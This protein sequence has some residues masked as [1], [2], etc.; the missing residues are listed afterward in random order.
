LFHLDQE[1][2][3]GITANS[4]HPG[5]IGTNIV[6]REVG[7]TMPPGKYPNTLLYS[8]CYYIYIYIYILFV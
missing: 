3:V 4:L 1:D 5:C 6:S 2:G 7:Q 8:K